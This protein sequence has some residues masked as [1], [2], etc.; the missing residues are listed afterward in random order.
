[1]FHPSEPR[2]RPEEVLPSLAE[3]GGQVERAE[4]AGFTVLINQRRP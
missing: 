3:Q 4:I 1:V 2:A